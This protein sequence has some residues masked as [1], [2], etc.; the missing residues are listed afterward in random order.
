MDAEIEDIYADL[1]SYGGSDNSDGSISNMKVY[2][3]NSYFV[4][5]RISDIHGAELTEVEDPETGEPRRGVFIPF[6]NSGLTVTPKKNVL[7]VCKMEMAQVVSSKYTHLLTQ[8]MDRSDAAEQKKL[9]YKQGFVGH[10]RP[11]GPKP[12]KKRKK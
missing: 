8:I 5:V 12:L 7:L 4:T 2:D 9:G 11:T 6:K 3:G 1:T 10:A